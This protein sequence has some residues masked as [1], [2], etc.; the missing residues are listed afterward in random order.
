MPGEGAEIAPLQTLQVGEPGQGALDSGFCALCQD[1][2]QGSGVLV[3][4]V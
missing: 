2:P 1:R 4:V 3:V